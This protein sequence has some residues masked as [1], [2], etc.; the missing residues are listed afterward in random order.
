MTPSK[1]SRP[2]A[3]SANGP[4]IGDRFGGQ[5]TDGASGPHAE[6]QVGDD[7]LALYNTAC[8]ALTEAK[9]VD[10]VR[11]IL[12]ASVAMRAYA[13][14]A[15]NFTME[16]D[17]VEIRMRAT[18]RSR[19]VARE[20]KG[21]VRPRQGRTPSQNRVGGGPVSK[22]TLAEAGIDKHLADSARKLGALNDEDFEEVVKTARSAVKGVIRS[23]LRTE[24]KA[25]ARGE[26]EKAL[27][28]RITA[29]P[30]KL[31]GVL[32]VDPP[33]RFEVYSR[34]SGMDRAADNHYPTMTDAEL[35]AMDLP[36]AAPNSICFLWSTVP[37]L[38][39]SL[40][41]MAHWQ[42]EYKSH[43]IWVKDRLGT[44]HWFRNKHETLLVGTR[45]NVPAPTPGTQFE[46][47]VFA[48]VGEHSAKPAIFR[49]M[50]ERLFPNL[51]KLEMFA[52][53]KA[54]PGWDVLGNEA[55]P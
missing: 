43:S 32:Y 3:V 1:A 28:S 20:A 30:G 47:V 21:N 55:E 38:A 46:S 39:F 36:P 2:A 8:R 23:A 52:R 50:I 34:D 53:G 16:M 48:P 37:K 7:A 54:A 18:R 22:A 13:R 29:M 10:E 31:F 9:R 6:T 4:R 15:K 33:T 25:V 5:I 12:D 11:K 24:D 51:P 41:L 49:D 26:K 44:G 42:F 40:A 27:G 17:A 19:P 45:G 35:L 14:Q